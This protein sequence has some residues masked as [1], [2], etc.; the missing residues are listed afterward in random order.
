MR[1]PFLWAN[2]IGRVVSKKILSCYGAVWWSAVL[3][4]DEIIV[5]TQTAAFRQQGRLQKVNVC[6]LVDFSLLR[7]DEIYFCF[8]TG[9]SRHTST[10]HQLLRKPISVVIKC[11]QTLIYDVQCYFVCIT[12][13]ME[14]FSWKFIDIFEDVCS[15]QT[16]FSADSFHLLCCITPCES[17]WRFFGPPGN[18]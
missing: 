6:L 2:E 5:W 11:L 16:Y 15:L 1:C 3:H 17:S 4:E 7:V 10:N 12:A 13:N 9:L 8:F 14:A 18:N